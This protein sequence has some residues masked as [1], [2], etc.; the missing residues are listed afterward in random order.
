MRNSA[1]DSAGDTY[2]AAKAQRY[3]LASHEIPGRVTR[4]TALIWPISG[5]ME[6]VSPL[7]KQQMTMAQRQFTIPGNR[8]PT[9]ERAVEFNVSLAV[10]F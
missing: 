4:Q 1:R 3:Q 6:P 2:P 8:K 7:I 5:A 10:G 9:N